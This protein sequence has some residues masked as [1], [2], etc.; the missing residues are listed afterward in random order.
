ML[1]FLLLQRSSAE[2]LLGSTNN[3][4]EMAILM[5][6]GGEEAGFDMATSSSG[7]MPPSISPRKPPHGGH[8]TGKGV[9]VTPTYGGGLGQDLVG[10]MNAMQASQMLPPPQQQQ[11][12]KSQSQLKLL[13]MQQQY[14]LG[15]GGAP[16]QPL[17]L[18]NYLQLVNQRYMKLQKNKQLLAQQ[19]KMSGGDGTVAHQIKLKLQRVQHLMLEIEQQRLV[20][21]HLPPNQQEGGGGSL[22][23]QQDPLVSPMM[24]MGMPS[25]RGSKGFGGK[26]G[27]RSHSTS[28]ILEEEGKGLSYNIQGLSLG[29]TVSQSSARSVSRFHQIFSGSS[30]DNLMGLGVAGGEGQDMMMSGGSQGS[31]PFSPPQ[32]SPA[33][34]TR[35]GIGES[36]S[37]ASTPSG[38]ASFLPSGGKQFTEIQ[39]FRPGVP[40]QP[41]SQATEPA[42]L[43]SKQVSMP[44]G[45]M[46]YG[47]LGESYNPQMAPSPVFTNLHSPMLGGG[48]SAPSKSFAPPKSFAG[49]SGMGGVPTHKYGRSNSI[50]S[51]FYGSSGYGGN[52]GN[53]SGFMNSKRLPSPSP[54]KYSQYPE[55]ARQPFGQGGGVG[56]WGGSATG[57]GLSSDGSYGGVQ[58]RTTYPNTG[59]SAVSPISMAASSQ[60][61]PGSAGGMGDRTSSWRTN[62]Q[63]NAGGR[64]IVPP[65]S[66]PPRSRGSGSRSMGT[67]HGTRELFDSNLSSDNSWGALSM[68]P[69][70]LTP[71]LSNPVWGSTPLATPDDPTIALPPNQ[72]GKDDVSKIWDQTSRPDS[73]SSAPSK[74]PGLLVNPDPSA[75]PYMKTPA[76]EHSGKGAGS[77]PSTPSFSSGSSTW[78]QDEIRAADVQKDTMSPEPTFAEWLSGKKARLLPNATS[79]WLVIR[80]INAQVS[81]KFS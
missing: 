1:V 25:S 55:T 8:G 5:A 50:G 40:W 33:F 69:G 45:G 54:A 22:K 34:P 42:Q 20:M 18:Q 77:F 72:W 75:P 10:P 35:S 74:P 21:G 4:L 29:A 36:L 59:H 51:G 68:T 64:R 53:G 61:P 81:W 30:S 23:S 37:G 49:G 56:G 43:Y 27:G 46:M 48:T 9:V 41:R 70:A 78:G 60:F 80:N 6:S 66:L 7:A 13:Q 14:L 67:P 76:S 16:N 57:S 31:S 28:G 15:P 52:T 2:K 79:P 44:A 12:V 58:A 3:N 62:K 63:Q 65:S 32:V 26:Q 38:S 71:G 24:Q 47:G 73:F 39:E 19:L 17:N 11:Q